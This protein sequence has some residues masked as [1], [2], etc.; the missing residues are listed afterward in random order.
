[1]TDPSGLAARLRV[2]L[3]GW[4]GRADAHERARLFADVVLIWL[5]YVGT[6]ELIAHAAAAGAHKE[7][8]MR[9]PLDHAQRLVRD[10]A[11]PPLARWDSIYYYAIAEDGYSPTPTG[12][13]NAAAFLPLYPLLMRWLGNL[14]GA[15]FFSAALWVSRICLLVALLLLVGHVR[16]TAP[17]GQR[18][19]LAPVALL[20]FPSAFILISAYS[21]SLF[22]VLSLG[23]FA[24]AR[25]NRYPAAA[26]CAFGASATRLQGLALIPSLAALAYGHGRDGSQTPLRFLPVAACIAAYGSMAG[27]CAAVF[28]DPLHHF[29][30]KRQLWGQGFTAPWVP[31]AKAVDDTVTA[32]TLSDLG[33]LYVLLQ[34]PC[35]CLALLALSLLAADGP[36]RRW[37]ELTF[38]GCSLAMSL[39]GGAFGGLPRFMLVLFPIFILL[40]KLRRCPA[41]WYGY[42]L[43]SCLLQ[44]A[45]IINYVGFQGPPP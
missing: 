28:G 32:M 38:A 10:L 43:L 3:V 1:M 31:V 22:L 24:L 40:P 44:A 16:D 12:D 45:L 37:P 19:I 4:H 15:G 20:S 13:P 21:E 23:A 7:G 14:T 26:L 39:F 18:A 2:L 34:L 35:L 6:V 29:A 17:T 33:S 25:L 9:A 5:A 42:V 27:Y 11:A 36:H 41:L 8:G 30:V